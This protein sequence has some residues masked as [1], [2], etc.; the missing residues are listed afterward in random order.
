MVTLNCTL[1]QS[2]CLLYL[3]VN[4]TKVTE[5]LCDTWAND[6]K[7]EWSIW[8]VYSKFEMPHHFV[9]G[10]DDASY[11]SNQRGKALSLR[12]LNMSEDVINIY[13]FMPFLHA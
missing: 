13:Y 2:Y 3:R 1:I 7:A 4:K 6:R 8:M 10:I 11:L 9:S 5:F 12:K